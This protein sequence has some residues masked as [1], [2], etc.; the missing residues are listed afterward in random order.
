MIFCII[1]LVILFVL[2]ILFGTLYIR[3]R[4][5]SDILAGLVIEVTHR[6]SVCDELPSTGCIRLP[7][8]CTFKNNTC[9][10]K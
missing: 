9:I 10:P 8:Y 4:I 1:C 5:Q 3:I 6:D 7:S 2:V